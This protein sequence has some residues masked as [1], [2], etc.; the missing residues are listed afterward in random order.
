MS[1][2]LQLLKEISSTEYPMVIIVSIEKYIASAV[3]QAL[4]M[5]EVTSK[6]KP[7]TSKIHLS[8]PAAVRNHHVENRIKGEEEVKRRSQRK[9][10][11]G[12]GK[13]DE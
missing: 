5:V 9:Q 10:Q 1:A 2:E 11:L 8:H 6:A 12:S 7:R 3:Q 4:Q 13:V